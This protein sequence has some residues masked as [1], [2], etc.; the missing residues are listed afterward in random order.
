[1]ENQNDSQVDCIESEKSK[2]M[3]FVDLNQGYK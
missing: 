1:M 2:E 3:K